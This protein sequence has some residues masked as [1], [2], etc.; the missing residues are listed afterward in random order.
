VI[1]VD[2]S[3][4]GFALLIVVVAFVFLVLA[5]TGSPE[6]FSASDVGEM[7]IWTLKAWL[8]TALPLWI[9]L[10]IIDFIIGGSERRNR[11]RGSGNH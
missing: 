1:W 8:F 11:A 9:T 7:T 3:G 2:R 5:Y 10:R 4:L 6:T